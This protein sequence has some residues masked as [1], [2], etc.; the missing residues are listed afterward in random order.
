MTITIYSKPACVQC[1]ATI[2]ALD[3]AGIP[4]TV[5]DLTTDRDAMTFVQELG[6]R[7]APVVVAE[8]KH[9][10]GYRPDMIAAL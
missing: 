3:A 10:S 2:R 9:W 1:T 4:Y 5:I 7:Q 8:D 6:Y